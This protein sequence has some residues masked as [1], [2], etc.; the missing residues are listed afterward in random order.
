MFT[1]T[2]SRTDGWTVLQE[3]K[4][5]RDSNKL[6]DHRLPDFWNNWSVKLFYGED[7]NPWSSRGENPIQ[8]SRDPR[9]KSDY[10]GKG[11]VPEVKPHSLSTRTA[12]QLST[13]CHKYSC[14][15]SAWLTLLT[16]SRH[17]YSYLH[18]GALAGVTRGRGRRSGFSL[19]LLKTAEVICKQI[20]SVS[21]LFCLAVRHFSSVNTLM[22][23]DNSDDDFSE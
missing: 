19:E 15:R 6:A 23:P 9:F 17:H 5:A 3:I 8:N 7:V 11:L 4:H 12:C 21:K 22:Y 2:S 13:C 10:S 16:P 14:K 1:P 20:V 18:Q